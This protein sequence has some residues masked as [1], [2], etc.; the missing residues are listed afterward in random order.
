MLQRQQRYYITLCRHGSPPL[1]PL[2][3]FPWRKKERK[4][5]EVATLRQ[6][7]IRLYLWVFCMKE[8]E[9]DTALG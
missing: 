1:P 4:E 9:L 8:F 2:R 5:W 3:G 7:E 6:R